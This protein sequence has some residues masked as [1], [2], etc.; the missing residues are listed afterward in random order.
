MVFLV[1]HTTHM[2][3]SIL[4]ARLYPHSS[5]LLR[6]TL[7]CLRE[8]P[9]QRWR[10]MGRGVLQCRLWEIP[11]EIASPWLQPGPTLSLSEPWGGN[12]STRDVFSF[13]LFFP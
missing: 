5:C 1:M 6:Y 4:Q 10:G 13:R 12:P 9:G 8:L 11:A 2:Q 3:L 7:T